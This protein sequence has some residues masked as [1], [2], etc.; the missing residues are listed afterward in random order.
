MRCERANSGSPPGVLDKSAGAKRKKELAD[1]RKTKECGDENKGREKSSL[2]AKSVVLRLGEDERN[3]SGRQATTNGGQNWKDGRRQMVIAARTVEAGK[4]IV[5]NVRMCIDDIYILFSTIYSVVSLAYISTV[6]G[7]VR[8]AR[9]GL[10]MLLK[11]VTFTFT[12]APE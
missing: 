11:D 6:H 9:N 7:G 3:E 1:I 2:S 4:E 5:V 8:K 12:G 10:G